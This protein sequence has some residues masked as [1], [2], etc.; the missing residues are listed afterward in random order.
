MGRR[1]KPK[2]IDEYLAAADALLRDAWELMEARAS[3]LDSVDAGLKPV[4]GEKASSSEE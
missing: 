1:R 2:T 4:E 3:L